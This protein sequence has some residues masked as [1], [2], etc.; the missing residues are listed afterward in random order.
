MKQ[1][2]KKAYLH[3]ASPINKK[4]AGVLKECIITNTFPKESDFT[5]LF[6][7]PNVRVR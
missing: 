7:Q 5:Q 4:L 3:G 1:A 2:I 6:G